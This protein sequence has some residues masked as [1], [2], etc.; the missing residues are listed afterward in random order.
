MSIDQE[1]A[2]K[3]SNRTRT[4][5]SNKYSQQHRTRTATKDFHQAVLGIKLGLL[6]VAPKFVSF[7]MFWKFALD[8]GGSCNFFFFNTK[9]ILGT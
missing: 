5:V 9:K 2:D 7:V 4:G 6:E 8:V 1:A 3:R